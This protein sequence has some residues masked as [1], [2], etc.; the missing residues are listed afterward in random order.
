MA[1]STA[2]P[3]VRHVTGALVGKECHDVEGKLVLRSLIN[4][5]GHRGMMPS[6]ILDS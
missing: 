4:I 5:V 3:S 2:L 1:I 6:F